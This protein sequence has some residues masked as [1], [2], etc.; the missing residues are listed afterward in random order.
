MIRRFRRLLRKETVTRG[1]FVGAVFGATLG[2]GGTWF[3]L[4]HLE[5][6]GW[7]FTGWENAAGYAKAVLFLGAVYALVGVVSDWGDRLAERQWW[8]RPDANVERQ[9]RRI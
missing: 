3:V 6:S 2:A 7:T 5:H 8:R 9:S 4:Q 1:W